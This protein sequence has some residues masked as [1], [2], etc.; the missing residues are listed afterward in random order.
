MT[1]IASSRRL[2]HRLVAARAEVAERHVHDAHTLAGL[3]LDPLDRIL[4]AAQLGSVEGL[5]GDFLL[6]RLD[7][8]RTVG[9]LV[10]LVED[11]RT[12]PSGAPFVEG[13]SP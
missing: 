2:V 8:A 6:D 11:W 5:D 9:D 10:R 1:T 7:R 12:R 4:I 13:R 3:G